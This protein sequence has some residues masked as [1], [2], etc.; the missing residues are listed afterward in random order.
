MW[1][2]ALLA[3]GAPTVS[4]EAT[5]VIHHNAAESSD[6]QNKNT[7]LI[8][9]DVRT[10]AEFR[11]GHVNGAINIDVQSA[12]FAKQLAKLD[13]TKEVL[14]HCQSGGRSRRTLPIVSAADFAA[15]HHLDGGYGAWTA[16]GLPVVK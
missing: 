16:A 12:D 6:L 14:V 10:D 8:V 4:P 5:E 15:V 2:L 13:T 11:R 1:L 9:L 7:S 3:C